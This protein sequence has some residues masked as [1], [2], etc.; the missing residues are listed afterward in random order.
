LTL[1]VPVARPGAGGSGA[2]AR[3]V[4]ERSG[5]PARRGYDGGRP[6]R[7]VADRTDRSGPVLPQRVDRGVEATRV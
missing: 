3:G 6:T 1:S 5:P 2:L 7:A 4:G